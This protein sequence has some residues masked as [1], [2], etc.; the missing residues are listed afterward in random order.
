M[1]NLVVKIE[2]LRKKI[3]LSESIK[4]SGYEESE[5]EKLKNAHY[6]ATLKEDIASHKIAQSRKSTCTFPVNIANRNEP[7][8]GLIEYFDQWI[9]DTEKQI[10][11]L[12]HVERKNQEIIS[13]LSDEKLRLISKGITDNREDLNTKVQSLENNLEK[14]QMKIIEAEF[15]EK[16]YEVV[17]AILEDEILQLQKETGN[18][19]SDVFKIKSELNRVKSTAENAL[20]SSRDIQTQ[21]AQENSQFQKQKFIW[22]Q[23]LRSFHQQVDNINLNNTTITTTTK[24]LDRIPS[25]N[26]T[27]ISCEESSSAATEG[28]TFRNKEMLLKLS[29]G[30]GETIMPEFNENNNQMAETI[31]NLQERIMNLQ[32]EKERLLSEFETGITYTKLT[33]SSSLKVERQSEKLKDQQERKLKA[34][35]SA[36]I[37]TKFMSTL[38]ATLRQLNSTIALGC[39]INNAGS[40]SPDDTVELLTTCMERVEYLVEQSQEFDTDNAVQIY[41]GVKF[42]DNVEAAQQLLKPK[43]K[44]SR[45]VDETSKISIRLEEYDVTDQEIPTRA[46]IKRQAKS[47]MD[48]HAKLHAKGSRSQASNK[49]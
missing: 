11:A 23:T 5:E 20:K 49:K 25:M 18:L 30:S 35:K 42:N 29:L 27:F 24:S 43:S 10:N 2:E 13:K 48:Y 16:K 33:A 9:L 14:M 47:V 21:L 6:I 1:D 32:E 34:L 46:T 44:T 22:E 39:K 31:N 19:D 45:L 37:F 26:E 7:S 15:V 40:P 17:I 41:E 36:E 28:L 38:R 12:K 8:K 4:K 3:S